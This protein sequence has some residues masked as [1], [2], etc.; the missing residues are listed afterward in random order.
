[1]DLALGAPATGIFGP[2]GAGKSTLLHALAGLVP[3]ERCELAVDGAVIDGGGRRTPVHRRGV[4]VVFQDH[5]LFPH[6]T[7]AD[8]LRYGLRPGSVGFAA[9]VELLDLGPRLQHRPA[10]CSGGERQ[11]AALGRALLSQPRLLLL[12]EPLASLD[13]GLKAQILPYLRRLRGLCP[14]P[15][16]HVSHDLDELLAVTD[17]LVLMEQG[18]VV[19]HGPIADLA[20]RPGV[21]DRLHDQGLV[22][23]LPATVDGHDDDDGISWLRPCAAPVLRLAVA[24]CPM[25]AGAPVEL[26][27]RPRDVVLATAIPAGTSLGGS[28]AGVVDALAAGS[29]GTMVRLD[30]GGATLLAEVAPRAVR[31]LGLVPGRPLTALWKTRAAVVRER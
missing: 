30:L 22:N 1:V 13:R 27:L 15:L 11:R 16:I 29:G 5:R 24:R 12:D 8:N 20:M 9:V 6:L 19:A 18:G 2:S 4:A 3:A 23:A 31:E 26:L 14:A 28:V 25:P 21:L 17:E 10:A 7:L